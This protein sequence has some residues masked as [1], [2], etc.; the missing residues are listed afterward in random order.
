[1]VVFS[2]YVF[3]KD[4]IFGAATASFQIEGAWNESGKSESCWDH[5]THFTD[6]IDDHSNGDI[7]CD[8]YHKLDEDIKALKELG[9]DSYRF[10]ISWPRILPDG[11]SNNVNPD[12][13]RYYNELIDKLLANNITPLVTIYHWDHPQSLQLL[14]GWTNPRMVEYFADYARVAFEHFGDRVKQWAT[15]NEPE[16]FCRDTIWG[17]GLSLGS[18]ALDAVAPYLCAH[19]ILR[20]HAKAYHIY[21]NEFSKQNGKLGIVLNLTWYEPLTNTTKD[22]DASNR[23]LEFEF[24]IYA[25]PIFTKDGD[26]PKVV[27]E[28]VANL[29]KLQSFTKSRLPEF[30]E[31]DINEIR[32]TADFLGINHYTTSLISDAS[33]EIDLFT[34]STFNDI[35]VNYTIDPSW[36]ASEIFWLYDVPWGL[37][38]ALMY[39]KNY[40]NNHPVYITEN[41]FCEEAIDDQG[42][43][44]Y[45]Q[46]YLQSLSNAISDGTNIVGHYAWSLLD[47]FE[48]Y[49]GYTKKFGLYYVNFTD[50][51]RPRTARSSAKWL[52]NFIHDVKSNN[53]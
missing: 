26:F 25:H 9:V 51:S 27:K 17:E 39:V 29:S 43:V 12:G 46:G 40:T 11:F 37:Y 1:M 24:G 5:I 52:K 44:H 28:R 35:A 19:T 53:L 33:D 15:F 4:F 41:G 6:K 36:P 23:K 7:A 20:A 42:R 50:P 10:S 49:R 30:T 48:W 38:K 8:S 3:P 45:Y 14:G 16:K 13:I 34:P 22:I 2:A 32:D 18:V 47:N 31:E 21:K